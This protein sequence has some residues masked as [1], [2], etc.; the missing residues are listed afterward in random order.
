[1][2]GSISGER[3]WNVLLDPEAAGRI[4]GAPASE[5]SA[6]SSRTLL[7]IETTRRLAMTASE[8]AG[9]IPGHLGRH[10]GDLAAHPRHPGTVVLHDPLAALTVTQ[11]EYCDFQEGS[12]DISIDKEGETG[13]CTFAPH[14]PINRQPGDVSVAVDV[15]PE[16]ALN[17]ILSPLR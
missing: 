16:A 12:V 17:A 15:D 13:S 11:P 14:D 6:F 2:G 9:R 5:P 1:M 10:F 3:E 7:P 8:A 4:L